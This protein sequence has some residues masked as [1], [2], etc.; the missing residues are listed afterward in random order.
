MDERFVTG[1]RQYCIVR[2]IFPIRGDIPPHVESHRHNVDSL[3]LF[4]G[5]ESGLRGLQVEVQLGETSKLLESPA[6]V[7]IP[8]GVDHT[9]RVIE[10]SG[11]NVNFVLYGSYDESL[12]NPFE[13]N[14][15]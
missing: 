2:E 3:Y 7:F 1:C 10:G 8:A 15:I 6:S 11:L 12:L 4:L 9:Y 13:K 14:T 5:G